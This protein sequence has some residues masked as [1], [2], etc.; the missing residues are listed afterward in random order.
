M[1]LNYKSSLDLDSYFKI[2]KKTFLTKNAKTP[3]IIPF[4]SANKDFIDN[5]QKILKKAS[6]LSSSQ[7]I[8]PTP[9]VAFKSFGQLMVSLYKS[10][11]MWLGSFA[12]IDTFTE[13]LYLLHFSLFLFINFNLEIDLALNKLILFLHNSIIYVGILSFKKRDLKPL[14]KGTK[15]SPILQNNEIFWDFFCLILHVTTSNSKEN[16]NVDHMTSYLVEENKKYRRMLKITEMDFEKSLKPHRSLKVIIEKKLLDIIAFMLSDGIS[17]K[18][19]N[20]SF[21]LQIIDY[22]IKILKKI[23]S[24]VEKNKESYHISKFLDKSLA[25]IHNFSK[26]PIYFEKFVFEEINQKSP[27]IKIILDLFFSELLRAERK[28]SNESPKLLPTL[29]ENLNQIIEILTTGIFMGAL[30]ELELVF[31]IFIIKLF[32]PKNI[33]SDVFNYLF[34]DRMPILFN[35]MKMIFNMIDKDLIISA[36]IP[37]IFFSNLEKETQNT[38]KKFFFIIK[39]FSL[40]ENQLNFMKILVS[41]IS[42]KPDYSQDIVSSEELF[43][44]FNELIFLMKEEQFIEMTDELVFLINDFL[45]FNNE[46]F[47]KKDNLRVDVIKTFSIILKNP[48]VF[49][50]LLTK[51]N[52]IKNFFNKAVNENTSTVFFIFLDSFYKFVL[53]ETDIEPIYRNQFFQS[54]SEYLKSLSQQAEEPE[55]FQEKI[56]IFFCVFIQTIIFQK[57]RYSTFEEIFNNPE[58]CVSMDVLFHEKVNFFY[59]KID[60]V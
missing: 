12:S 43:F 51:E 50:K 41:S 5:I 7:S 33:R 48:K 8:I 22:S 26:N 30:K 28:T 24:D 39:E 59:Y 35:T 27:T 18:K 32:D 47:F 56:L 38:F 21:E 11:E 6:N 49:L 55:E 13:T 1:Y 9:D 16:M 40:S 52:F 25:I 4:F 2:L 53:L 42:F 46:I 60:L 57:R 3:Q 37:I 45:L 31:L 54:L 23:F 14:E 36:L 15:L 19:N 44:I 20:E 34:D 29:L 58:N 17:F 10:S